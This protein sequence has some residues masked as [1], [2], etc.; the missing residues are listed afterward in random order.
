MKCFRDLNCQGQS[1]GP[2]YEALPVGTGHRSRG[3]NKNEEERFNSHGPGAPA[4]PN[5]SGTKRFVISVP[6]NRSALL[7]PIF[8]DQSASLGRA[9]KR[10]G[11]NAPRTKR[12]P[13]SSSVAF[14]SP[15]TAV[16]AGPSQKASPDEALPSPAVLQTEA[17]QSN[18]PGPREAL[19]LIQLGSFLSSRNSRSGRAGE[20]FVLAIPPEA[21]QE[22]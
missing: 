9:G 2:G 19:P 3:Q 7:K 16:R 5:L 17:L 10:F 11:W 4:I 21:C 15:E 12:S 1:F 14:Q 22:S 6:E 13:L 18:G 20:R 8:P